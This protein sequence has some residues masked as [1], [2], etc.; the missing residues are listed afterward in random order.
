MCAVNQGPPAEPAVKEL[1]VISGKGGT[2]K[3]SLVAAFAALAEHKVLADCDVDA[4]DLHLIL[5]PEVRHRELF[6]AGREARIRQQDCIACGAC[7]ARCRY[8]AI[9]RTGGGAGE[10]TF[11]VDPLACEGCGVCV[12]SCPVQAIDFHPRQSGEWFISDTRHGP[13]VH[14]Q[15]GVAEE[16]SGKLVTVVRRQA[17]RL[18]RERG[19][20]L[21]IIDGPPGIGCPVIAAVA[22]TALALIITEPT[23]SG[24]HDLARAAELV[25]Q[26]REPV[27]VCTNKA[28]I[29]PEMAQ[30]IRAWCAER[31]IPVAAELPYDPAV[32]RAQL[33]G[34]SI[35]EHGNGAMARAV[36][37]L[38][39]RVQET[40]GSGGETRSRQ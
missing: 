14:A 39:T 38:W 17:V 8:E 15:L 28:D 11:I 27:I 2:G 21:V 6:T 33:A 19:L 35:V 16:N 4:A 34:Q 26:F 24:L 40:L 10:A 13:M 36:R 29:N 23:V 31:H 7:L 18:A 5:R 12:W 1:A 25:A 30:Q 37:G 3:T 9:R 22:G 32:T 20:G